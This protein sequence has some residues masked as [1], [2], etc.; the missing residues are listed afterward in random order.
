MPIVKVKFFDL[1]NFSVEAV[2]FVTLNVLKLLNIF[3]FSGLMFF[4][5]GGQRIEKI[6]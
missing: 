2:K 3:V 5:A 6:I 1:P 4:G